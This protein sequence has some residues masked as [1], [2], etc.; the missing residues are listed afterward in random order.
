MNDIFEEITIACQHPTTE[1]LKEAL[2]ARN[3]LSEVESDFITY[4]AGFSHREFAESLFSEFE[5]SFLRE[6]CLF[7]DSVNKK[8]HAKVLIND[9]TLDM[10]SLDIE[11]IETLTRKSSMSNYIKIRSHD[12]SY[13]DNLMPIIKNFS[14]DQ[15]AEYLSS[16]QFGIHENVI[17]ISKKLGEYSLV[18][19]ITLVAQ[20]N[21]YMNLS[22]LFLGVFGTIFVNSSSD[23]PNLSLI[24]IK[25]N[26]EIHSALKDIYWYILEIE[27]PYEVVDFLG[28]V[29]A[30]FKFI[31]YIDDQ[32]NY[33]HY[34]LVDIEHKIL[35][36]LNDSMRHLVERDELMNTELI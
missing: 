6:S 22:T 16:I 30:E 14:P 20:R 35:T 23:L 33:F 32:F 10:E 18:I 15:M 36:H 1:I 21:I 29:Q 11:N 5:L 19:H 2:V 28:S 7:Y 34:A 3:N 8:I 25:K 9:Q 27:K 12:G 4:M 13:I 31:E 26:R 17:S 24:N